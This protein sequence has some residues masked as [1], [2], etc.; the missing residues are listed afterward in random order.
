MGSPIRKKESMTEDLKQEMAELKMEVKELAAAI[1]RLEKICSR[2]DHHI[3][4]VEDV[5]ASA[6]APANFLK[7][8]LER[9]MGTE[10]TP[11]VEFV[12]QPVSS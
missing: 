5:M 3:T 10:P 7:R 1:R 8:Q 6:K 2:M 4:N 12:P 9:L 11:S